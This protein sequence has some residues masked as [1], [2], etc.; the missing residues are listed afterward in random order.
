MSYKVVRGDTLSKI[1]KKFG[2]TYQELARINGISDPNK[3]Q[4][5]QIIKLPNSTISSS[6]FSTSSTNTYKIVYGDTLSKIANRFGTTY[7]ELARINGI[8]N[9]NIIQIGQVIKVPG[10]NSFSNPN[11]N[12]TYK[13]AYN[14]PYHPSNTNANN[15]LILVQTSNTKV[16]DLKNLHGVLKQI[17]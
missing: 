1:A 10:S 13:Q 14:P 11:P 9:P 17:H 4:V 5:G 2:T 8:S 15:N 6:S 7:Q 16:L 3:I 12:Q